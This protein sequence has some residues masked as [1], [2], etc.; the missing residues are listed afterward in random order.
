MGAGMSLFARHKDGREFPVEIS[1]GPYQSAEGPLVVCA[2]RDL[3]A[4]KRL[5]HESG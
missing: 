5:W 4:R 2:I 3:T 1:L